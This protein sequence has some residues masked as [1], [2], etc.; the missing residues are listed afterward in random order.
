MSP[1]FD[2]ECDH[3]TAGA[4]GDPGARVFYLQAGEGGEIVSLRC[5][6]QQVAALG[7][8]FERILSDLAEGGEG[9]ATAS[10]LLEPVEAAF[11][12]GSLVLGYDAALDRLVLL[13]QEAV[14]EDEPEGHAARWVVRR[15][16]ARVF[17]ERARQLVA[18]GRPACPLCGRPA[19]AEGHSC[20]KTNGH[21][22]H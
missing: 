10:E 17:A 18:A 13:I 1:P 2:A 20:P 7:E 8:Y 21:L 6:K 3:F 5:E 19:D 4:V 14:A 22:P 15:D 16:Q 12:V 11:V 9:P